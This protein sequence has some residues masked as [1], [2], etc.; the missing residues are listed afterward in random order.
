MATEWKIDYETLQDAP[1]LL[2]EARLKPIQGHRFQPTGFADLGPARYTLPDGTE[3]LLVESVQSVANRMELACWETAVQDLISDLQGLPYL[4]IIAANN[5]Q[6]SNSLLEAHRINSEYARN[7][8]DRFAN[9]IRYEKDGRVDWQRFHSSLFKYD[10]NSLIHGC[11]LEE[12]GGR[13]RVTRALS[14]FVEARD[15]LVAESGGVKNNIVQ[16]DLKGGEGNVPFH[17]TEF[18]AK[19]I[20]AYFNLDLALLRGHGLSADA[21]NLLIALSLFK[22]RRF[23]STGLRLRTACDLEVDG[24]LTVT[25]PKEFVIADEKALLNECKRL[26]TTCKPLFAAP[27]VTNVE[28]KPENKKSRAKKDQGEDESVDENTADDEGE[29]E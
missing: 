17:R 23:L 28:W 21:T 20:K 12:I 8:H 15:V 9:E 25:R 7:F 11:F 2:M 16:P 10:P 4:K 19:E 22:V 26:I 3:M 18:V 24:D 14:G 5:G 13:L 1:R 29:N 27:S 6:L